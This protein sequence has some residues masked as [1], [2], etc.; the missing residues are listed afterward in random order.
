M[1]LVRFNVCVCICVCLILY[2]YF[3]SFWYLF[4]LILP[5]GSFSLLLFTQLHSLS[6]SIIYISIFNHLTLYVVVHFVILYSVYR[7]KIHT[8]RYLS[9]EIVCE[10]KIRYPIIR[11]WFFEW[12]STRMWQRV[13]C[14]SAQPVR[15]SRCVCARVYA[16]EREKC[17]CIVYK[18]HTNNIHI[19]I[20]TQWHHRN[21]FE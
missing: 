15:K 5:F 13:S 12:K 8:V 19:Q 2:V 18:T 7:Y 11:K 14:K 10:C 9:W 21:G 6:L 1:C 17:Y 16:Y 20:D 4:S 3:H